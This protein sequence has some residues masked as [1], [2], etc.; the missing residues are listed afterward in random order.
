MEILDSSY[1]LHSDLDFSSGKFVVTNSILSEI[2]EENALMSVEI[3][4]KKGTIKVEEPKRIFIEKVK[5]QAKKT[6]DFSYLSDTDLD[7]LAL[8]LEKNY[9]I[10]TDDYGI[11]NVASSLKIKFRPLAQRKITK[12][13][14]WKKVC[15]GCGRE[16]EKG[17]TCS[18]CGS[19]LKKVA[20]SF[21]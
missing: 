13:L 1:I 4:L 18:V 7:I 11:Q 8:A 5:E 17:E 9:E 3:A 21:E 14:H 15:E 2:K 6:G 19:S 12:N 16:Y 10:L 20:K